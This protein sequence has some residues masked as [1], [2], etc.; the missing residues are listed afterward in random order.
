M[1]ASEEPEEVID[2]DQEGRFVELQRPLEQRLNFCMTLF[3]F[4]IAQ[5][6][7]PHLKQFQ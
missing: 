4:Q 3:P 7:Q 6:R 1:D 2:G 5:V